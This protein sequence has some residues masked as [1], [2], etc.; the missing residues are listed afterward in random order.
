[1]SVEQ[2]G[3]RWWSIEKDYNDWLMKLMWNTNNFIVLIFELVFGYIFSPIVIFPTSN[4]YSFV[5]FRCT[6]IPI[7]PKWT[8]IEEVLIILLLPSY[9][10]LT[11]CLCEFMKFLTLNFIVPYIQ[12]SVTANKTSKAKHEATTKISVIK[13]EPMKYI[14]FN[15]WFCVFCHSGYRFF[16]FYHTM[17]RPRLFSSSFERNLLCKVSNDS[18]TIRCY[19]HYGLC[20]SPFFVWIVSLFRLLSVYG[21]DRVSNCNQQLR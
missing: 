7:W 2:N 5:A 8:V 16:I 9:S 12:S 11:S 21:F 13:L 15:H 4:S 3:G 20:G 18:N 17:L 14:I 10:I 19:G 6:H 1:M